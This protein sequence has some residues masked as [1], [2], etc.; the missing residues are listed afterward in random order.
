MNKGT[1][2]PYMSEL[3][4]LEREIELEFEEPE[5][6]G[7][8]QNELE[9]EIEEPEKQGIDQNELELEIEEPEKQGIRSK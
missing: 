2:E 4:E 8:D 1:N 6:Q 7:I 3:S 9:L 5:K